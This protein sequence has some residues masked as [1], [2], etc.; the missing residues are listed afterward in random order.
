MQQPEDAE[1]KDGQPAW[2]TGHGPRAT[3]HGRKAC[4]LRKTPL[5]Q[6]GEAGWQGASGRSCSDVFSG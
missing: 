5:W 3:G 2:A 4:E 6:Q 1:V